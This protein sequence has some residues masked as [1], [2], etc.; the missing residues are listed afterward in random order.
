L[1][2]PVAVNCPII[3][4]VFKFSANEIEA[5]EFKS[6]GGELGSVLSVVYKFPI[7]LDERARL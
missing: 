5:V 3:E 7:S 6:T 4:P 2:I 1:S